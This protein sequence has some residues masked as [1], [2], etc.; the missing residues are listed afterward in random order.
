LD[1]R[2]TLGLTLATGL[3][4]QI[5]GLANAILSCCVRVDGLDDA[6]DIVST[7]GD[8][9]DTVNISTASTILAVAADAKVAKV[10]HAF[11]GF[12]S[13]SS[14]LDA[15]QAGRADAGLWSSCS[16]GAGL[17]RRRAAAP[18]CLRRWGQ[19]RPWTRGTATFF[20]SASIVYHE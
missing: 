17:A 12:R 6:V 13:S 7:G 1:L 4:V 2:G 16:K 8:G 19:H 11:R 9:A 14:D 18:M 20:F 5:M 15:A 3:V 10:H